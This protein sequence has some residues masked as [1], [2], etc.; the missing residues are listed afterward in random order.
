E[1]L[2]K[3][4][5]ELLDAIT[6]EGRNSGGTL[7]NAHTYVCI[8]GKTYWVKGIA[9]RGLGFEL[10]ASRLAAKLGIGPKVEIVHLHPGIIPNNDHNHFPSEICMGSE[11]LKGTENT[12][13]LQEL[14]NNGQF[15]PQ[16]VDGASRARVIVFQSWMGV[17]DEQA[18]VNLTTGYVYCID[19]G[20]CFANL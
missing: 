15:K 4:R 14:L 16:S 5:Y 8:D 11:D 12:K 9:Q 2:D 10:I 3:E 13:K 6:P 20:D 19:N 7:S 17:G 1:A 18:L